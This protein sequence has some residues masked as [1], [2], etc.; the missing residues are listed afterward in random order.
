MFSVKLA[1]VLL[2]IGQTQLAKRAGISVR[3]LARIEIGE[4]HPK[5][6]ASQA[7]DAAL[8]AIIRED[9]AQAIVKEDT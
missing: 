5:A 6:Q 3:E 2:G 7:L 4:V 9:R 8:V 1:R